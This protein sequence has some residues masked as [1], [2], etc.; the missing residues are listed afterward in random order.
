MADRALPPGI[1]NGAIPIV[2]HLGGAGTLYTVPAGRRLHIVTAWVAV[3]Q[4][5]SGAAAGAAFVG[6]NTGAA[7]G[8]GV[9]TDLGV[10]RDLAAVALPDA[11]STESVSVPCLDVPI[12]AGTVIT[13]ATSGLGTATIE[14]GFIGWEEP[15]LPGNPV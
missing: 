12:I 13:L 1:P 11:A 14:G 4:I 15:V 10:R 8:K 3:A 6:I 9:V 2:R 7:A 5:A